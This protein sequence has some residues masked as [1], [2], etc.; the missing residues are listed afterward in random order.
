MTIAD[1]SCRLFEVIWVVVPIYAVEHLDRHAE[2]S[3][4]FPFIDAGL[5]QPGRYRVA[6]V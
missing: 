3:S 5:H 4:S 6:K 1:R 2:K